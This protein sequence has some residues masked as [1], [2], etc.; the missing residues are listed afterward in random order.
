MSRVQRIKSES[1]SIIEVL[2]FCKELN[3]PAR[4][5]GKWVWI[6]FPTKPSAEIRA[7]L[8]AM[9]FRWSHR[10]QQ[11]ANS[12]KAGASKPARGYRPW[13]K[14][15]TTLLDDYVNARLAVPV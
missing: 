11:W 2:E 15:A 7:S 10:R 8:K 6:D 5:V 4:V 13:D 12:C 1:K 9:G 3:L 14:Y